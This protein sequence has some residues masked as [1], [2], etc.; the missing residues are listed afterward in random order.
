MPVLGDWDVIWQRNWIIEQQS[1]IDSP[2]LLLRR[3]AFVFGGNIFQVTS[4]EGMRGEARIQAL[5]ISACI[6]MICKTCV[7]RQDG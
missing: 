4:K 3:Y 2:N 6:L 7:L 1:Q 5:W